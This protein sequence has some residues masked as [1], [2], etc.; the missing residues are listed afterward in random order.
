MVAVSALVTAAPAQAATPKPKVVHTVASDAIGGLPIKSLDGM[1][2]HVPQAP[3]QAAAAASAGTPAHTGGNIW[4]SGATGYD[5]SWPQCP[6]HNPVLPPDSQ[7][8]VVGVNDGTPFT[9]LP[10]I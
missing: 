6:A 10:C 9:A 1:T 7:V 8:A 4:P 2:A 3:A 5:I